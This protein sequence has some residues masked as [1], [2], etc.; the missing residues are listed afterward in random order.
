MTEFAGLAAIGP[1]GGG[2]GAAA[3]RLLLA[4]GA[5]VVP[6]VITARVVDRPPA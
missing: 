4:R 6:G 5:G 1:G 2:L 3:V